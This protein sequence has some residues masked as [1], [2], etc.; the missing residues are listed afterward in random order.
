MQHD[1]WTTAQSIWQA[2]PDVE[3]I[4]TA[5][6]CRRLRDAVAS[7]ETGAARWRDVVALTRQ[8][9]LEHQ[10]RTGV[11]DSLVV[12]TGPRLPTEQQWKSARCTVLPTG[13]RLRIG[14]EPWS[15]SPSPDAAAEDDLSRVY[16]GVAGRERDLPA[17]PFWT[18]AL[19]FG[20]YS[21][22]GQREAARTLATAPAGGTVI[23]CL[24]TGEGKTEVAWATVL[25]AIRN[26]GVAVMVV[27]T[28]VLALDMERRLRRRLIQRGDKTAA[29]RAFAYTGSL[30][31]AVKETIRQDIRTG[32]QGMVIAAPEAVTT[33]L[34]FALEAAARAGHLTH[35]IIDEAHIVEQWGHDFRPE[36]QAIAAKR[37]SWLRVAPEGRQVVTIA[38]SATLT[39]SQV[40]TLR[41]T[42]GKPSP[43]ELVWASHTRA[44]PI[45]FVDDFTDQDARD[46]AVM[47]AINALP[48]PLVLYTTT[49]QDATDWARRLRE[50][51]FGRVTQLTGDSGEAERRTVINGWRGEDAS[52]NE[53]ATRF[54][55][56]VGTSAFGLGV[57]MASVRSVVHACLP[58][59]IDRY[60]QEVGRGGRDGRACV[61]YMATAPVDKNLA[62]RLSRV[63]LIGD[64]LGWVRWRSMRA[65]ARVAEDSTLEIDLAE[66]P[67]YLRAE[68][69]R[70][71]QWNVRLLNLME[72]AGLIRQEAPAWRRDQD[73][74]GESPVDQQAVLRVVSEREGQLNNQFFFKERLT[75]QRQVVHDQQQ[76]ALRQLKSL[77]RGERCV[78]EILA[79][80]YR[81]RWQGGT[82]ATGLS[83]RSCPHCRKHRAP[84]EQTGMRR[85][86]MLPWPASARWP[87]RPDPLARYRGG[88][89]LLSIY[90][91]RREHLDDLLPDL[92]EKL[93]RLRC[94]VL[95]G[96]G[97]SEPLLRRVQR[98]AAPYPV[99]VDRDASL[100]GMY[101]SAL[102]WVLDETT[103]SLPEA[104]VERLGMEAPTYLVH[105]ATLPD[106][107][108]PGTPL[109]Y[110]NKAIPLDILS[111]DPAW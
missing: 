25:P 101:E 77:L 59:T 45:Y 3:H 69:A 104:V 10:A 93:V 42:F 38:M 91:S 109:R 94:G 5:G 35:L 105:P 82:L 40:H 68:S 51:G 41:E 17:D 53:S 107:H 72:Q 19:G 64:D 62:E 57:D 55:V 13:E 30:D 16:A 52:G 33:G 110:M 43:V 28:V 24:P 87:A 86:G 75:A 96:P 70:N 67:A 102:V 85:R 7:L 34:S 100:L 47:E 106:P 88:S 60:Y 71:I 83:C 97:L 95:G 80:Y 50:A 76:T 111:K 74:D 99:I 78:S 29:T 46:S 32:Q 89:P 79:E 21:S 54:D 61:A 66:L 14:G 48:R 1:D 18:E 2:W 37:R 9:L 12:P 39:A 84:D 4:P 92:L 98:R 8:V 58:E 6:T 65:K 108:R 36:F 31:K 103:E 22:Y 49:R 26:G 63:T 90:W 27:P 56:V 15:P 44:E 81:L 23:A 20:N 11:Q 73:E